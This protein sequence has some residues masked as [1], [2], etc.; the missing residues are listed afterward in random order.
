[1]RRVSLFLLLVVA[2]L[3]QFSIADLS[4]QDDDLIVEEEIVDAADPANQI[5]PEAFAK[6]VESLTVR[7]QKELQANPS[8]PEA[9]SD[10]CKG[11]IQRKV[12]RMLEREKNGDKPAEKKPAEGGKKKSS[13]KK[14]G[15]NKKKN[16]KYAK[17]EAEK[18]QEEAYN[19]T[20]KTIVAFVGTFVAIVAG[21]I[22]FINRK[23]K[24]AGMYYP[25][26]PQAPA[27]GCCG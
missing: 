25:A 5:N 10:R 21:V 24:A 6:L 15:G 18:A 9:L 12:V 7:C 27:G 22:V 1:M 26:D 20:L 17:L 13:G 4:V 14:K 3:A 2:L 11:E 19:Q 16:S 8:D 23:L